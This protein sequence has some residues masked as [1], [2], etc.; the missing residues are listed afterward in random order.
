MYKFLSIIIFFALAGCAT[1]PESLKQPAVIQSIEIKTTLVNDETLGLA[2][3]KWHKELKAGVY[4]SIGEDATGVYFEGP[5][6]CVVEQ[7]I[8]MGA[9]VFYNGGF[10]LPKNQKNKPRIFRYFGSNMDEKSAKEASNKIAYSGADAANSARNT[11]AGAVGGAIA[12]AI[13]SAIIK[14]SVGKIE[15]LPEIHDEAFFYEIQKLR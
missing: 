12:G 3:V 7:A 6:A 14:S 9:P 11:P 8:E 13:G 5:K 4:T 2:K 1:N 15:F 10:W